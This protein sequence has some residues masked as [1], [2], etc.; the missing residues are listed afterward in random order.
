[1]ATCH[2]EDDWAVVGLADLVE[3]RGRQLV[4]RSLGTMG[5]TELVGSSTS[6]RALLVQDSILEAEGWRKLAALDK[7]AAGSSRPV[8]GGV[9]EAEHASAGRKGHHHFAEYMRMSE[10]G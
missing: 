6:V 5:S 8:M 10:D 4:G 7:R 1:M 9:V 3:L 2:L